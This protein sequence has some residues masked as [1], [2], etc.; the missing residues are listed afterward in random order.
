KHHQNAFSVEY[1][2]FSGCLLLPYKNKILP[3]I[4]EIPPSGS[5]S[6][7]RGLGRGKNRGTL[8]VLPSPKGMGIYTSFYNKIKRLFEISIQ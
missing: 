3:V 5:F 8:T 7:W 4:V 6:F 1:L 2:M